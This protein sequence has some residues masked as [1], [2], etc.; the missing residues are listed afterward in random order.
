M[1]KV[2]ERFPK[3]VLAII[4]GSFDWQK[5]IKITGNLLI[6]NQAIEVAYIDLMIQA[7]K[8]LGPYMVIIPHV[9]IVHAAPIKHVLK[10]KLVFLVF[11]EPVFFNCENDPVHILIGLCA[12]D[13]NSHLK[14]FQMIADIF[15][16][17]DSYQKFM[18]CKDDNELYQLLNSNPRKEGNAHGWTF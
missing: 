3:E 12:L 4:E 11:K 1:N 13:S 7:V 6:K 18:A 8:Q 17:E 16:N 10:N 9:A 2:I 5:A 14:H 15:E